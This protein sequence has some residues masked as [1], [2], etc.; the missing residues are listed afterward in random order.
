VRPQA[1]IIGDERQ[2]LRVEEGGTEIW[3]VINDKKIKC[4]NN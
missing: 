2:L 4:E 1:R 3:V